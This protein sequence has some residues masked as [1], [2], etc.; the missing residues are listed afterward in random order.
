MEIFELLKKAKCAQSALANAKSSIKDKFL[1]DTSYMLKQKKDEIYKAN[2][3][4]VEN[5]KKANLNKALIDRLILNDKRLDSIIDSL[6]KIINLDDPVNIVEKGFKR[7][8]GLEILKTRVP[9]GVICIIYESRPN[10]TIDAAALCIKAGNAAVLRGGKESVNTNKIFVSILKQALSNCGL[11]SNAILYVEDPERAYIKE[12]LKANDFID[13]IIPRGGSALI[14]FVTNNSTIPVVKHDK[15]VCHV[16]LDRY[17]N[18]KMAKDIS[19]NAKVNRPSV[20]NAMET[21][22]I[23]ENVSSNLI[24][25]IVNTYKDLNVE[26]RGC[27][28]VQKL[29]DVI[30][31]TD[32]DWSEEYLDLIVSIKI[33]KGLEEAID[34][35]NRY[36]S[37]HSDSIVTDNYENAMK[38]LKGVDSA[39]VYVN[40][41]TRFTDGYE[42][43]F[44]AEMGISTQKLHCR[45]P[46]G[47]E[48]LTTY[49]YMVLGSG[50]IR[51]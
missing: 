37:H 22:L 39:A 34:H 41:S 27:A 5:A 14:D 45:G 31:A 2:N 35:I 26:V 33:V 10:V 13:L 18:Y 9:V 36:G 6:E 24:I 50:Q 12:L 11:D 8:N 48:G 23:D 44:G 15:G 17:C 49:K 1:K 43:G 30:P 40:A 19:I 4:D 42:F 32:K 7:P 20:C 38:F 21:L 25:D 46:M 51:T 3:K 29:C 28:L 47:L 16:Y